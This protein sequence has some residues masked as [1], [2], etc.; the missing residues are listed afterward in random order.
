M[1]YLFL[2]TEILF[3]GRRG[4]DIKTI[5]PAPLPSLLLVVYDMLGLLAFHYGV[6]NYKVFIANKLL[7]LEN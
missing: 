4:I 2:M 7:D 6:C 1:M 5:N 3:K